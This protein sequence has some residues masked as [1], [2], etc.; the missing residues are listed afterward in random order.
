[1]RLLRFTSELKDYTLKSLQTFVQRDPVAIKGV[2]RVSTR[3][4]DN[5]RSEADID[6][7][8]VVCDEPVERG[9]TGLGP[10]PLS[11]FVAALGY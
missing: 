6:G 4:V 7:H 8:T 9:G 11:Y 5:C 3:L 10:P 1:M 2:V